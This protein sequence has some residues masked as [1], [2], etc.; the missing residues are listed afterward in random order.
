MTVTIST[1][2]LFMAAMFVLLGTVIMQ[3]FIIHKYVAL[4]Q[5]MFKAMLD[6]VNQID[7]IQKQIDPADQW[8]QA[9]NDQRQ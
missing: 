8:K 5:S 6:M 1:W 4:V 7:E 2:W 9:P 3:A